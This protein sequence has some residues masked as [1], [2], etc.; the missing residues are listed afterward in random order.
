MCG[1]VTLEFIEYSKL[2]GIGTEFSPEF[3]FLSS[4]FHYSLNVVVC[5]FYADHIP[6]ILL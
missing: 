1:Y 3:G 4:V 5:F 2:V 6:P